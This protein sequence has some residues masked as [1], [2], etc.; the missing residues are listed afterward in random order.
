MTTKWALV[1]VQVVWTEQQQQY[2]LDYCCYCSKAIAAA[3]DKSFVDLN[4]VVI[5][6][7]ATVDVDAAAA[8][9]R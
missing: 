6:V 2:S 5:E 1:V 3:V 8:A 4:D 9:L 7:K